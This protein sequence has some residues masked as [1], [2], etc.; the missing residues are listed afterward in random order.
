[1]SHPL[2][3]V[4]TL[5]MTQHEAHSLIWTRASSLKSLFTYLEKVKTGTFWLYNPEIQLEIPCV[6]GVAIFLLNSK[7]TTCYYLCR[8]SHSY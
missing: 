8:R 7:F 1:M 3:D 2:K 4:Q 6:I 5:T